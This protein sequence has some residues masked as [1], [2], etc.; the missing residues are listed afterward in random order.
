[1]RYISLLLLLALSACDKD[2]DTPSIYTD[3]EVTY[4]LEPGSE[5]PIAGT[6]VFKERTNGD[7]EVI[8]QLTG[9]DGAIEHPTH[10]HYGDI[11][12]PDAEMALALNPVK[13]ETGQSITI[14]NQLID[15]TSFGY[16]ELQAFDGHIK[17]HQDGGPNKQ[18][19]LAYGNVGSSA[20]SQNN[21]RVEIAVC[22]SE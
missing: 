11:S 5:F 15:E 14:F 21:G 7:L 10:L 20:K 9:T 2:S 12:T 18:V 13:G 4:V 8:I 1:M 22:K 6:A 19:I 3:N 17:V 16:E